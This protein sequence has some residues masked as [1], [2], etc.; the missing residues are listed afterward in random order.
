MITAA[1]PQIVRWVIGA[2]TLTLVSG[3][4]GSP[5]DERI[6]VTVTIRVDNAGPLSAT[7]HGFDAILM[8]P[9]DANGTK[10]AIGRITFPDIRVAASSASFAVIDSELHVSSANSFQA[11]TIPILRGE[12]VDWE[13]HGNTSVTVLGIPVAVALDKHLT[14]PATAIQKM[15][16][17]NVAIERGNGSSGVLSV[18]ADATFISTSVLELHHLGD[19][20]VEVSATVP[21]GS[22]LLS[23]ACSFVEAPNMRPPTRRAD[24]DSKMVSFALDLQLWYEIGSSVRVAPNGSE[25]F[26]RGIKRGPISAVRMGSVHLPNFELRQGLNEIKMAIRLD[27][28]LG[29]AAQAAIGTF[30]GKWISGIPQK[31]L[32]RGPIRYRA[33]F[34]NN[35]S[36]VECEVEAMPDPIFTGTRT[37][38]QSCA[39]CRKATIGVLP[40]LQVYGV[41][42]G[43]HS[44]LSFRRPGHPCVAT[45]CADVVSSHRPRLEPRFGPAL[46]GLPPGPLGMPKGCTRV[47]SAARTQGSHVRGSYLRRF[48]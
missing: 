35:V 16:S 6:R 2:S 33:V 36:E 4:L 20:E 47:R 37:N 32:T 3:S 46:L 39:L 7:L 9:S 5:G 18:S 38:E 29:E 11:A 15:R 34:L 25:I 21:F 22:M 8:G 40:A 23:A 28:S 48:L 26:I 41:G 1:L 10:R 43:I 31:I 12:A 45:R 27:A 24:G 13:I 30:I 14:M 44:H 42:A 19:L 17:F